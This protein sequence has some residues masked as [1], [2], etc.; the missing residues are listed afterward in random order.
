M[1]IK[2][3]RINDTVVGAIPQFTG[4]ELDK[5]PLKGKHLFQN[6]YSNVF[7]LARKC[8]GKTSTIFEIIK[9]RITRETKVIIFCST[10][11]KDNSYIQIRKYLEMK[12]IELECY[13]SIKE[14]GEDHLQRIV[15][16]LEVKAEEAEKERNAPK[17]VKQNILNCDDDC[18]EEEDEKPYKSK[19]KSPELLFIF[20]DLSTELQSKSLVTLLK[21]NRH[22]FCECILSSQWLCDLSPAARRQIDYF[23]VFGGQSPEKLLS[24]FKDADI[25]IPFDTFDDIYH[26]ATEK[27]YSFLYIDTR[28]NMFR[29]NFN[30]Q[31]K[32]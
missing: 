6:P 27:Q 1:P 21:K 31:I 10:V 3:H 24:I 11:Y 30:L 23:L 12:H 14:D 19:H 29:R 25:S 22:F 32:I 7:L 9:G 17:Q 4:G 8:S 2:L 13:A 18:E 16:E 26:Y 5:R 28:L 15:D 20:D